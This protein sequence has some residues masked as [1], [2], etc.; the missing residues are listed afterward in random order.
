MKKRFWQVKYQTGFMRVPHVRR[1]TTET[2]AR[3]FY[4]KTWNMRYFQSASIFHVVDQKASLIVGRIMAKLLVRTR[5]AQFWNGLPDKEQKK[6][7]RDQ[8]Q[9]VR[10]ILESIL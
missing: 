7:L 4:K 10:E 3:R 5:F 6:I 1:F 9:E 2:Q 8:K